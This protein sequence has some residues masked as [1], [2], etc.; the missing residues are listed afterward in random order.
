MWS[1]LC[2]YHLKYLFIN[3]TRET[4]ISSC[5]IEKDAPVR[6]VRCLVRYGGEFSFF[7][8]SVMKSYSG[9]CLDPGLN[10]VTKN[11]MPAN[12]VIGLENIGAFVNRKYLWSCLIRVY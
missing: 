8:K 9:M 4:K 12:K 6:L 2:H 3:L 5:I 7:L 11:Y 1:I 10:I